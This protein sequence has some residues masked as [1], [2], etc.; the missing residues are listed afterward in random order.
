MKKYSTWKKKSRNLAAAFLAAFL[1]GS[2]IF[3]GCGDAADQK[4]STGQN[5]QTVQESGQ[6]TVSGR[7]Y[8][9]AAERMEEWTGIDYEDVAQ[10]DSAEEVPEY[11]GEIYAILDDN[12][13]DFTQE[14]LSEAESF[15]SY[16][17]LDALGR[18]GTATACIGQDIMP[19]EE[20]G[21]IGHVKP[22]GW[23]TVKYDVVDGMYLYN[24]CHLIAYELAAENDNEENL[25]TGTRY[26]NVEGMLPLENMVTDFVKET[27]YHVLYRVTP[28]YEGNNLVASGVEMEAR[29][30]EDNG[31]GICFHVYVYNIQPGI[32]IDYATGDSWESDENIF[33]TEGSETTEAPASDQ[34][35]G[36]EQETYILNTNTMKFHKPDCSS[37][38]DMEEHNR[39]EYTGSRED[40][41]ADGYEP[42][43]RCKP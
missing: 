10:A 28:V 4:A 23:H 17:D 25:I 8:S 1:L 33:D 14:E 26:M 36:A 11:E 34:Q 3:T 12:Q 13:P 32:A 22:T 40:L 7:E 9:A 27:D 42:C 6:G 39:Q 41:V 31:E 43:G 2:F 15:E 16:S 19:T 30:L 20:R 21:S 5:S 18:C 24:R 38:D 35:T 29:S 37:V